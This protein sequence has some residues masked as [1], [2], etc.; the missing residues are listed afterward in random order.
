MDFIGLSWINYSDTQL[1]AENLKNNFK[2]INELLKIFHEN[3]KEIKTKLIVTACMIK[4]EINY[5]EAIKF[6]NEICTSPMGYE[7]DTRPYRFR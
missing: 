4:D 6:I 2:F 5:N 1:L 7:L 3:K